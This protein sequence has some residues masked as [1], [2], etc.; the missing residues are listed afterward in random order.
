MVQ[1]MNDLSASKWSCPLLDE[2][3]KPLA[4]QAVSILSTKIGF[5]L[6][7]ITTASCNSFSFLS[8]Y[9]VSGASRKDSTRQKLPSHSSG[10]RLLIS[11]N[12]P[13]RIPAMSHFDKPSRSPKCS[14]YCKSTYDRIN[15][16][17]HR[18]KSLLTNNYKRTLENPWRVELKEKGFSF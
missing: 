4:G 6:L 11:I 16:G 18:M 15:S 2:E 3:A 7:R 14:L 13:T 5:S 1:G 17:R 8:T 9:Q 10:G 12:V